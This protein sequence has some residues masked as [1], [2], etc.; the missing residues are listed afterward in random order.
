M[1]INEFY[2]GKGVHYKMIIFL[3]KFRY[4]TELHYFCMLYE[5]EKHHQQ[6]SEGGIEPDA[7]RCYPLLDVSW[8]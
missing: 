5:E 1:C 4:S 2:K 8:F 7:G 6:H 3:K